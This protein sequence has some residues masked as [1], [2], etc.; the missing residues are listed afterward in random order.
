MSYWDTR[1]L[2]RSVQAEAIG[3]TWLLNLW[4]LYVSGILKKWFKVRGCLAPEF[5]R[6]NLGRAPPEEWTG[7]RREGHLKAHSDAQHQQS[8]RVPQ[9][10]E[11][12]LSG[13]RVFL[14]RPLPR[15]PQAFESTPLPPFAVEWWSL[16]LDND[17]RHYW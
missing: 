13:L 10:R 7:R 1:V 16:T 3:A 17:N 11:A 5:P 8:M 15:M 12:D 2:V 14:T 9:T 4:Y 6:R